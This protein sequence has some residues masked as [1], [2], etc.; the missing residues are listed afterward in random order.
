[1]IVEPV[2]LHGKVIRLEPL[3]EMHVPDLALAGSDPEI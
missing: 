2:S 3:T 1:M